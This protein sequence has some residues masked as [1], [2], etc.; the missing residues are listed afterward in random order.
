MTKVL[1]RFEDVVQELEATKGK[2]AWVSIDDLSCGLLVAGW[3][4]P[5][6]SVEP[7]AEQEYRVE[8]GGD[9]KATLQLAA[10][11]CDSIEVQSGVGVFVQQGALEIEIHRL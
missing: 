6:E 9:G 4:G 8:F 7:E 3:K 11:A 5:L 10:D 2:P 1:T